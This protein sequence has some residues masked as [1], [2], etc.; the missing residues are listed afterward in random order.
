MWIV[1]EKIDVCIFVSAAFFFLGAMV[2]LLLMEISAS[3]I[4]LASALILYSFRISKGVVIMGMGL[5]VTGI[6]FEYGTIPLYLVTAFIV[7]GSCFAFYEFWKLKGEIRQIF[8]EKF[9]P[10]DNTKINVSYLI[11]PRSISVT[12]KHFTTYLI[13]LKIPVIINAGK[14]D[15][16]YFYDSSKKELSRTGEK[17]G[18]IPIIGMIIGVIFVVLSIY[19]ITSSKDHYIYG[20]GFLLA[21]NGSWWIFSFFKEKLRKN[22]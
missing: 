1:M 10:Q 18:D 5:I 17:V 22:K 8:L 13:Q 20:M 14:E 15:N 11:G 21:F 3:M 19:F 2:L 16:L 9:H 6:S 4:F 7:V 12:E